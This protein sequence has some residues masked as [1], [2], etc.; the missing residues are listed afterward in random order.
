MGKKCKPGFKLKKGKCVRS[1]SGGGNLTSVTRPNK[2]VRY[3]LIGLLFILSFIAVINISDSR[4]L[5]PLLISFIFLGL[6]LFLYS[7]KEFQDDLIGIRVKRILPSIGYG[8]IFGIVFITVSAFVPFFSLAYPMYPAAIGENLRFFLI[9]IMAPMAESFFFV[10]V[11][12]AFMRN[13]NPRYKYLWIFLVSLTFALFHLGSFILGF[14]TLDV[15]QGLT[16]LSANLSAFSSAF[17]F[18]F[19]I[20]TVGLWKGVENADQTFFSIAHAVINLSAWTF[21]VFTFV[22]IGALL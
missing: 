21:S 5:R 16:A 14:Y 3:V 18:N 17:I 11:M 7:F 10:G 15:T 2:N 20:M 12:F 9:N 4:T 22:L 13:F 8:A 19:S 1:S 6:S